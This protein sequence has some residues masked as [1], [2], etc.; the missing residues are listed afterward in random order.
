MANIRTRKFHSPVAFV[1][2]LYLKNTKEDRNSNK[3]HEQLA[4]LANG[5]QLAGPE[6]NKI[7]KIAWKKI[8]S[9]QDHVPMW[10]TALALN[11]QSQV[12][13]QNLGAG[14]LLSAWLSGNQNALN[15]LSIFLEKNC[16]RI[17]GARILYPI[18]LEV[19]AAEGESTAMW[20]LY[21]EHKKRDPVKAL[22]WLSAAA[23]SD[24]QY[25]KNLAKVNATFKWTPQRRT[26]F[27]KYTSYIVSI[28][29]KPRKSKLALR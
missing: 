7:L 18:L 5:V 20:N 2:E 14:L 3:F 9:N 29:K 16:S 12:H 10:T 22:A 17:F 23:K 24:V 1:E 21:L 26:E 11:C 28:Q 13:L 15:D 25:K 8:G 6:K 27:K 19:A 4:R